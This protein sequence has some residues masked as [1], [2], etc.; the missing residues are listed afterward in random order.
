[1]CGIE[2]FVI[3]DRVVKIRGNPK[4]PNMG[5]YMT[6]AKGQSGPTINDYPERLVYPLKRAGAR[7][8]GLWQRISWEEAYDEIAGRIQKSIDD[9]H[10]ERVVLHAGRSRINTEIKRFLGAIGSPVQLNHRALCSSSKRGA[11][12]VSLGDTDWESIDAERCRYFLNFGSNFYEAHQGGLHLVKR[13]I[14]ARFDHGATLVTFDVR[15]S[16]TAG[17]SPTSM[18]LTR[19]RFRIVLGVSNRHVHLSKEH[20]Q[21]LFGLQVAD[22]LDPVTWLAAEAAATVGGMP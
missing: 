15:L 19:L 4:D 3:D 1:M 14:K 9:G 5:S 20:L 2:G 21:T 12:Y 17:R 10:P 22:T 6:C 18:V 16:N 11:N 13:V 8:E 7:G